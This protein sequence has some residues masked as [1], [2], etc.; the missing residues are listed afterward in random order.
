MLFF[1]IFQSFSSDL[2]NQN[3]FCFISI[4]FK[5]EIMRFGLVK[6]AT[7]KFLPEKK[8]CGIFDIKPR[9]HDFLSKKD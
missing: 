9:N 3:L 8:K 6:T 1:I 4:V 5:C 7:Q 2:E